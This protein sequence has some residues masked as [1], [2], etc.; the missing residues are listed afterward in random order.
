M[1]NHNSIYTYYDD[2]E[3]FLFTIIYFII[4]YLPWQL[5][6]IY[7]YGKGIEPDLTK[8]IEL[9]RMSAEQNY[10][11]AQNQLGVKYRLGQGVEQND[12]KAFEL[13]LKASEGGNS[14]AQDNLGWMYA[15]GCGT[16]QN[17]EKAIE[18]YKKSAE[19]GYE[20]ANNGVAWYLHLTGK[21][22]EALPWAEKAVA[23]FPETPYIIDTLAT[24]YQDLGRYDEALVEF[25]LC[26]K[27]KHEQNESDDS[28]HQTEEKITTLKELMKNG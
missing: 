25:E 13:Y 6:L 18:W 27:L 28:I 22:K 15:N 10:S 17:Y 8:A 7:E 24:V 2:L 11:L 26:L 9:Y 4:G 19:N 12:E 5:G 23:A 21:Y 3:S 1:Y 14:V 20:K 16:E